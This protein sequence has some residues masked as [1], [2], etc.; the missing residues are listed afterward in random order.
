LQAITDQAKILASEGGYGINFSMLRPKGSYVKGIGVETSGNIDFMSVFDAMS[1]T[2]TKGSGRKSSK[3][4]N[5]I[6]KG[7]MMGVMDCSQPAIEDFITAKQQPGV[8]SKFNLSVGISDKFMNAV[9]E[10]KPWELIFPETDFEKYDTEWDGV[11]QHWVDK[12]YPVNIWKTYEDANE[13]WDLILQSTYNRAEPG[14]IFLDT[15]NKY[16]NLYYRE[17]I[18]A[19]NPCFTGDTIVNT[20]NGEVTIKELDER[21]KNTYAFGTW[22]GEFSKEKKVF[23]PEEKIAV[24]FKTGTKKVITVKLSNNSTFKCTPDHLIATSTGE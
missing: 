17:H 10:H 12:G 4:K 13:L 23:I 22:S 19:S 16:N 24:A 1:T 3:G 8:L 7:A 9:E 15:V 14:V 11:I 2:L 18:S 6:R 5:K 20:T 21:S